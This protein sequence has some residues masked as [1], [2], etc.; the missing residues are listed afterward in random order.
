MAEPK[1]DVYHLAK[2]GG[3]VLVEGDEGRVGITTKA[4][5]EWSKL[6]A[7]RLG[8]LKRTMKEWCAGRRLHREVYKSGGKYGKSKGGRTIAVFKA[9]QVRLYGFEEHMDDVR[10][11]VIV[12]A[13]LSKKQDEAS[14]DT[15][16]R[17][18]DRADAFGKEK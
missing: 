15:I 5:R 7:M 17:L 11:F 9:W 16:A 3:V 4:L 8:R 1:Q 6:D 13:D 18:K 12:D 14:K 2:H 10:T